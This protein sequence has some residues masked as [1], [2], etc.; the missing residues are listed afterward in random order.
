MFQGH[1]AVPKKVLQQGRKAGIFRPRDM[2]HRVKLVKPHGTFAG[3]KYAPNWC[4]TII[5]V[6][7]RTSGHVAATYP[8]AHVPATFSCVCACCDFVPATRLRPCYMS[9]LCALHMFFVAA[10]CPCNMTPPVC[11]AQESLTEKRRR[12]FAKRDIFLKTATFI[13][14]IILYEYLQR[15]KEISVKLKQSTGCPE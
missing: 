13:W 10:R 9:P 5:K 6:L 4:S 11:S 12:S 15:K 14:T 2:S 8:Q 7:V 1:I 3:T